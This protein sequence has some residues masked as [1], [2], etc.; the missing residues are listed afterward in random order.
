MSCLDDDGKQNAFIFRQFFRSHKLI[1]FTASYYLLPTT[2]SL[3]AVSLFV[4]GVQVKLSKYPI[5]LHMRQK[6]TRVNS[7]NNYTICR[8]CTSIFE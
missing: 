1:D 8:L 5:H 2:Y 6:E 4:H 3:H 7:E